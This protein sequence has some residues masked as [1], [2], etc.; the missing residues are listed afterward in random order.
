M[1]KKQLWSDLTPQWYMAYMGFTGKLYA[2][3]RHIS[4]VK[5]SKKTGY[6]E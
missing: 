3:D 6:N 5:F 4:P 1:R 2:V